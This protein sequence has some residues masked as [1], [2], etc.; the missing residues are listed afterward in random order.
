MIASRTCASGYVWR[1][2]D[3]YDHVCTTPE[4]RAA[5]AAEQDHSWPC[6]VPLVPRRAWADDRTCVTVASAF[7]TALENLGAATRVRPGG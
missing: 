7:V 6:P 3:G 2:A 4:R 1:E 5:V